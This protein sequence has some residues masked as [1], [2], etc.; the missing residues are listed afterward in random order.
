MAF[1]LEAII[2]LLELDVVPDQPGI[3]TESIL[4]S[5]KS[6]LDDGLKFLLLLEY[7]ADVRQNILCSNQKRDKLEPLSP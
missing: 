4:A 1:L 3:I 6:L 2:E 7:D 5:W